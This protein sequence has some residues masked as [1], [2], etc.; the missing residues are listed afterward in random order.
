MIVQEEC[1]YAFFSS[2]RETVILVHTV[3][4]FKRHHPPWF[5]AGQL[6]PCIIFYWERRCEG[7]TL[8]LWNS[9]RFTEANHHHESDRNTCVHGTRSI[10]TKI[11][12]ILFQILEEEKYDNKCDVYS[13][14]M[15]AWSINAEEYPFSEL[16]N[17]ITLSKK[18]SK[19]ERPPLDPSWKANPIIQKCWDNVFFSFLFCFPFLFI[20]YSNTNTLN[21]E[22]K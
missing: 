9:K 19:G 12:F 1:K 10:E 13:F 4:S 2:L 14:G 15:T 21:I 20:G 17:I 5:E 8:R 3:P 16:R 22:S 6:A 11:Y 18:V 7:K